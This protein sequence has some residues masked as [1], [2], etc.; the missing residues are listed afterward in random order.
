MSALDL[1]GNQ[2]LPLTDPRCVYV[3]EAGQVDVFA[4][5]T[6]KGEPSG[7]RHHVLTAREGQLFMGAAP[8]GGELCLL[9]VGGL[10]ARAR[11]LPLEEARALQDVGPRLRAYLQAATD[12]VSERKTADTKIG[13]EQATFENVLKLQDEFLSR[14]A[15]RIALYE[16][17][18]TDRMGR[19]RRLDERMFQ[20]ALSRLASIIDA[21]E[22]AS[23]FDDDALF[24]ALLAIGRESGIAFS[25]PAHASAGPATMRYRVEAVC[26]A[27]RV[28]YRVVALRGDWWKSDSGPILTSLRVEGADDAK[29]SSGPPV[30]LLPS[31]PGAYE[32][33]DPASARR[34]PVDAAT[35]PRL[36]AFGYVFYR[37]FPDT[38]VRFRDV[39][40][41]IGRDMRGD[42]LTLLGMAV[43]GAVLGLVVPWVTGKLFD[44]V[45]PNA[46]YGTLAQYSLGLV[47]AAFATAIFSLTQGI[48]VMRLNSKWGS[49]V[50]AALWDRLLRLPAPF[51]RQYTVGD[52]ANRAGAVNSIQ[53]ILSG[54]ALLAVL[55]SL[56]GV[57]NL[58]LLFKYS[59]SLALYA[60][61]IV[62]ATILTYSVCLWLS[63]RLRFQLSALDGKIQGLVFQL[64]GGISKLRV[65]ASERRGFAVWSKLYAK[66]TQL[67]FQ[68]NTY[69]N[70]IQVFNSAI[71][72]I[73]SAIIFYLV[74]AGMHP[75]GGAP[76]L[77]LSVGDFMAFTAA[78]TVFLSAGISISGTA[79][80][81]LNIIPIWRDALP[82]METLP[83][84]DASKPAA[85]PLTGRL[86]VNHVTFRYK[87][88]GP[89]I[90]DDVSFHVEPGE[91]IALV[92]PSGSGKSTV[93]RLLL[94]FEAP[95][96]GSIYYDGQ[97]LAKFDAAS[98]RRQIGVV[99]QNGRLLAGDIF[100]NIVGSLPLTIDDAWAAAE[101]AGVAED[102][103]AMPMGMFTVISE[104]A[105]TLSGGQRQRILIARALARRPK[106]IYFD[107]ATSALDNRTQEIVTQS[108]DKMRVTRVVIAH[109][110]STI[111]NADRI[112]VME[113]GRILQQGSFDELMKAPGLFRDLA[114]RQV[115]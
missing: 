38:A 113:K 108:L 104:G 64:L 61:G 79:F 56:H 62:L 14:L 107:E 58:L 17:G 35:L 33:Y 88:D 2:A 19:R 39:A 82:I 30:A 9:A 53:Q 66:S 3:V 18:E 74:H 105:S 29:D 109:R 103:R 99:L 65:S 40:A 60:C 83:E 27:S 41:F 7:A 115:S 34:A 94:G 100:T 78:F 59:T 85:K 49:G 8:G 57:L 47:S 70:I 15:G 77:V 96:I 89:K 21:P 43:A 20:G 81:V 80:Q 87:P 101:L 91:F 6:D 32:L 111:R 86:D 71:P 97:D 28:R 102:I 110:L 98:I 16:A 42:V 68:A 63:L 37:P 52:L 67:T 31:K 95:E 22:A 90:L 50:Q 84:V 72:V 23:G 24:S 4:V 75:A 73:S 92:G 48:A 1:P 45:I 93:L 36:H 55:S 10:G 26:Q 54:G 46:D 106:K 44:M 13:E 112:I 69:D 5:R 76:P 12:A 11:R 25:K 114:S 51:F